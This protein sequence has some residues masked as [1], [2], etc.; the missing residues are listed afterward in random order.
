MLEIIIQKLTHSRPF[1][2]L[3][4]CW[5]LLLASHTSNAQSDSTVYESA[6]FGYRYH[7]FDEQFSDWHDG[8]VELK[9][10][11]DQWTFLPRM[12]VGQRFDRQSWLA[13]LD[14]YK[15]L[16]NGDYINFGAGHSPGTI[17][18]KNQLNFEYYNPF[19]EW[20][21]SLGVRWMQFNQTGDVGAF[22]GSLSRYYGAMLTS[23]RL[24]VAY[25][26][27]NDFS[28][29]TVAMN[30]R[31]Y[32]SD[33]KF[34]GIHGAYGLDN[35]LILL[36]DRSNFSVGDAN[37]LNVG[38]DYNSERVKRHEWRFAYDWTLYNFES[39]TRNQHTI[40]IFYTLHDRHE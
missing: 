5:L 34:I 6:K 30:H 40:S 3:L 28:N 29:Y 17:F 10:V 37:L 35:R 38:L 18:V 12:T 21:H 24:T 36:S 33:I 39:S 15:T 7:F 16:K 11:K 25:G 19:G 22:T 8:V 27:E 9:F 1:F 14:V 2:G 31:Y 23:V 20:E 13:E 26:L 4:F 32:L